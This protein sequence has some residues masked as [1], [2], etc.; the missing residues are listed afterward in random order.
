MEM[1]KSELKQLVGARSDGCVAKGKQCTGGPCVTDEQGQSGTC[2][3]KYAG[4]QEDAY[5]SY[6]GG[7][8]TADNKST[9]SGGWFA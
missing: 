4:E 5:D 6:Y 8:S 2:G 7:S 3:C 1:T 9:N